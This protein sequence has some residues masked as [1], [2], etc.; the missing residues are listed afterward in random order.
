MVGRTLSFRAMPRWPG[1]QR[2][3]VAAEQEARARQRESFHQKRQET[4]GDVAYIYDYVCTGVGEVGE[5]CQLIGGVDTEQEQQ[6]IQTR[7]KG[8]KNRNAFKVNAEL[9]LAYLRDV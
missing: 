1:P 3:Q 8:S 9:C 5:A 7:S 6:R 2:C 4:W